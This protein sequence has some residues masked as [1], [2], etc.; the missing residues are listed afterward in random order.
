[1]VP[2][3]SSNGACGKFEFEFEVE[4]ELFVFRLEG[5]L[6][7]IGIVRV[8]PN[9][10]DSFLINPLPTTRLEFWRVSGGCEVDMRVFVE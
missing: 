6:M 10:A 8:G 7:L 3:D 5:V 9:S 2:L 4:F 1:M